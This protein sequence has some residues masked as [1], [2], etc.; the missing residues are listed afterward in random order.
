[1]KE[2]VYNIYAWS[3]KH[4]LASLFSTICFSDYIIQDDGVK[5]EK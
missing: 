3:R 5:E 2:Y 4:D 1:M